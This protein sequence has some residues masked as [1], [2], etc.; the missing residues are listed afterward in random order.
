M[1]RMLQAGVAIAILAAGISLGL[2]QQNV[3]HN[4][5]PPGLEPPKVVATE[6]GGV[7][8]G[9]K[10]TVG[11]DPVPDHQTTVP[12]VPPVA[13]DS[14]S[15]PSTKAQCWQAY[16]ASLH[17]Y[18]TGLAH[19]TLVFEWQHRSS[20]IIFFVVHSL[21]AAGL[22]FAWLQ[23]RKDLRARSTAAE[24]GHTVELSATGLKVSSNVLGLMIL[25]L[26][27]GFF[28]LYLDVVYPIK[29]IF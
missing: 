4:P 11:S 17:Y 15:E 20:I 3:D 10:P 14:I 16:R 8:K 6:S 21:V 25:A 24:P 26:S 7:L 19:R 29:E 18:E 23:F 22:F 12:T 28:Y 2:A 5:K 13:C 27:L 9:F 1:N